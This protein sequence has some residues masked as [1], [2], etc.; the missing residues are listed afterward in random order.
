MNPFSPFHYMQQNMART[1]ML[2]FV[3]SMTALCYLIGLYA[4]NPYDEN[5]RNI[6]FYK[7]FAVISTSDKEGSE[8]QL[9]EL[10]ADKAMT[11]E[12][13]GITIINVDYYND[14][15]ITGHLMT[16]N[17]YSGILFDTIMDFRAGVPYPV[18]HDPTEFK[19]FAET[20]GLPYNGKDKTVIMGEKLAKQLKIKIGETIENDHDK[21]IG[22]KDKLTL[23]GAFDKSDYGVPGQYVF[24]RIDSAF[25]PVDGDQTNAVLLLRRNGTGA[26]IELNRIKLENLVNDLDREKYDKLM[27]LDYKYH[28]EYVENLYKSFWLI[29]I[30]ILT[31]IAAVLAI[32][33]IGI[34]S[35]AL[36]KREFEFSV[37]KAIG[38]SLKSVLIKG[39]AEALILSLASIIVGMVIIFITVTSLNELV[40]YKRGQELYYFSDMAIVSY[41]ICNLVIVMILITMQVR[42]I[43]ASNVVRY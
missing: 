30:I 7:D 6:E 8:E 38:F 4:S 20:L 40:L 27:F 23:G 31:I 33:S 13:D 35:V 24:F 14:S 12:N 18:F 15:T 17:F 37:Y 10:L 34:F 11:F 1:A 19:Q 21:L 2:I 5:F 28:L 9:L 43:L 36:E 3:I 39:I 41:A 22:F 16:L 29:F 25:K 42:R 32:V 26:E